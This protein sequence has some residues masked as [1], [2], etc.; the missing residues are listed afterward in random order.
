[1]KNSTMDVMREFGWTFFLLAVACLAGIS[2]IHMS[3]DLDAKQAIADDGRKGSAYSDK[4]LVDGQKGAKNF[5]QNIDNKAAKT[6][7]TTNEFT[8]D[9]DT[10]TQQADNIYK[11]SDMLA[12]ATE[13]TLTAFK[14]RHQAPECK[15]ERHGQYQVS[16][17]GFR[18][19]EQSQ[20]FFDNVINLYENLNELN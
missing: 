14:N 17:D 5:R 15:K 4:S 3:Q 7:H 6:N 1:M 20:S 8:N 19:K 2:L 18:T 16:N 10:I 9:D 11:E 13:K 12:Q